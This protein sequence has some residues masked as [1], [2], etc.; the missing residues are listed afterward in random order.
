MPVWKLTPTDLSDPNWEASS[1]RGM[2]VVRA[3][4]EAAARAAAAE[5]FDVPTRFPPTGGVSTL[6][7]PHARQSGAHRRRALRGRRP[8]R[9]SRSYLL[10]SH[11]GGP[12]SSAAP[13]SY[14]PF[15]SLSCRSISSARSPKMI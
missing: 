11:G 15:I 12:S 9:N 5:A 8:D 4:D 7:Q 13:I 1:H 3:P 2:A 14:N 6:A 10:K